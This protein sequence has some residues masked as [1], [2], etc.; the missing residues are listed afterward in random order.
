MTRR[1]LLAW[2]GIAAIL[3]ALWALATVWLAWAQGAL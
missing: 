2:L 3:G 1:D